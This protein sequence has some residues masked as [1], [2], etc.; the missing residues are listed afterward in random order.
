MKTL[1][2]YN[3]IYYGNTEKIAQVIA[4]DLEANLIKPQQVEPNN[5][6]KFDIIGFGSGIYYNMHDRHLLDIIKKI[7]TANKKKAFIFSTNRNGTNDDHKILRELLKAK[8]F[9]IIGEFCCKGF[10]EWKA[11]KF[12]GRKGI[13]EGKPDKDDLQRASNFALD[14]KQKYAVNQKKL[15]ITT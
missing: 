11:V 5:L 15:M 2:V 8:G 12:F 3:S 9:T 1:V 13:N 10:E 7:P 6:D 4:K 14:L